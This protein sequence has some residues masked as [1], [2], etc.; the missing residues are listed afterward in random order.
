MDPDSYKVAMMGRYG[1]SA[2]QD[3][4]VE[5]ASGLSPDAPPKDWKY[6]RVSGLG[7]LPGLLCPHHDRT[8]SNGVLRELT[9]LIKCCYD[10]KVRWVS[11]STTGRRW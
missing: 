9:I 4:P 2:S 6:I 3:G 8:Q 10:T 5:D 11:V 1:N 7:L